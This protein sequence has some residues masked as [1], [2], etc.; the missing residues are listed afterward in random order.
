M[1]PI[2]QFLHYIRLLSLDIALASVLVSLT[3]AK[4]LDVEMPYA[5]S[6][7]LF[8][9]I[10]SI[11]TIDHLIDSARV[12]HPSMPRHQ[13]HKKHHR[14][15]RTVLFC[16]IG[17][18]TFSAWLLPS[19]TLR[20]GVIIGL[21][22]IVYFSMLVSADA[23]DPARQAFIPK[24]I[25]VG[26]I[27]TLGVLT[28]PLSIYRALSL[29]FLIVGIELWMIAIFN[30]LLFSTIE[31]EKD[32]KDGSKSWITQ[33][34]PIRTKR[35]FRILLATTLSLGVFSFLLFSHDAFFAWFQAVLMLMVVTL[36]F[37]R[38]GSSRFLTNENYRLLGDAVFMYPAI[39]L[40]W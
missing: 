36:E 27:Y 35:H 1:Q 19:E 6:V 9:A 26:A 33:F 5:V 2:V 29:K 38:I 3:I 39:L 20:I 14:I 37:V 34:G 30:L 22:V 10:W 15:I 23:R 28:G 25:I 16:A 40:F 31:Y 11:Y 7:C 17:A 13:F 32:I 21:V 12:H 4:M 8:L 24:E 18:G